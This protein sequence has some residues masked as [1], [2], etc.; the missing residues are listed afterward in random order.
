MNR[1]ACLFGYRKNVYEFVII[2]IHI[3]NIYIIWISSL[4][5]H[6]APLSAKSFSACRQVNICWTHMIQITSNFKGCL[7]K[8]F[9]FCSCRVFTY[10]TQ[11][12]LW[13]GP[14]SAARR[15]WSDLQLWTFLP[16]EP[17]TLPSE[18][19]LNSSSYIS[20]GKKS[21]SVALLPPHPLLWLPGRA[22]V[23]M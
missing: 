6:R 19:L 7:G 11:R 13:V 18:T 20:Q 12:A 1:T 14:M 22:T 2:L 10:R 15:G 17:L 21:G 3:L 4:K 16:C 9:F 23:H 5:Q 8:S